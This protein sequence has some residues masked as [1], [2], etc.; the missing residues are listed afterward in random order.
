MTLSRSSSSMTKGGASRI[1]YM[2]S[3][4]QFHST[5]F[6]FKS[7]KIGGK[8]Y[9]F[10]C[11]GLHSTPLLANNK[12]RSQAPLPFLDFVLSNTIAENSPLHRT[13]VIHPPF[14]EAGS[15]P[16]DFRELRPAENFSPSRAAR[17]GSFSSTRTSSAAI[18]T[19][20]PRGLPAK[21]M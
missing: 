18:A 1:L 14:P 15:A 20:H 9:V 13:V 2:H 11:V 5:T 21:T 19:A 8:T 3:T 17:S 10:S 4:D 12:H 6:S 7:W 16:T